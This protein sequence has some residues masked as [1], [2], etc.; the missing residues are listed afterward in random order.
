ME[1]SL[2]HL[3]KIGAEEQRV[4]TKLQTWGLERLAH[5]SKLVERS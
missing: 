3:A 2:R 1:T 5:V 4:V